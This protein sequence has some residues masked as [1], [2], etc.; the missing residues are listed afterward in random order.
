MPTEELVSI[1]LNQSE[2][3]LF[4]W[5]QQHWDKLFVMKSAGL[6]SVKNGSI[7]LNF[8]DIGTLMSIQSN[9][10]EFKRTKLI[11]GAILKV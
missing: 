3:E 8:D 11:G 7:T 10:V 6:F 9:R 4:V 2:A 1:K 5:V